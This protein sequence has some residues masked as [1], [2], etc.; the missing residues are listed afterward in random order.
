M[1]DKIHVSPEEIGLLDKV[2]FRALEI[3]M[4]LNEI[5]KQQLSDLAERSYC[6]AREFVKARREIVVMGDDLEGE[7]EDEKIGEW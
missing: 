5:P 2:A 6:I 7:E 3:M 1:I 4:E